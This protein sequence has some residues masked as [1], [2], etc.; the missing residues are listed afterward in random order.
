VPATQWLLLVFMILAGINF[1]RLY[2]LLVQRH[3][4]VVARDEELRLYLVFL[5]VGSL[6]LAVEILVGEFASGEPAVRSAIF[7]AVAIMTTTGFATADYTEWTA[8]AEMTLLALMFVGASAGS[9]G[10]SIKVIRYLLVGKAIRRELHQAVHREAVVP[11]RLSGQIVDERALRSAL[12]FVVLYVVVFALGAIALVI[13]AR[14]GAAD[15]TAFE[16]IGA[17]AACLGNV[18]PAFGFAGPFGS[19]EP[20]S[21]VS[22]AVLSVLMWLGRLE[23]IPVAI[24]LMRSYWRP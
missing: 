18:G 3:V 20:F 13:D 10:G 23:I 17:A 2:R 6:L 21:D 14:R 24:L 5:A 11:V 19:Y 9:T 1:L 8:L 12:T 15:V 16:A 22:T 4:R 7:Q